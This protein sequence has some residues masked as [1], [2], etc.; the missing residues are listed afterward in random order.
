MSYKL[1]I[2]DDDEDIRLILMSVLSSVEG[3]EIEVA[4]DGVSARQKL[5]AGAT[6]GII[7]DYSLPDISGETLL[8]EISSGTFPQI[9]EVIMLSARDDPEARDRWLELGAKAV[10]GKPFNPFELL[11]QLKAHL[12]I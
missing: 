2:I 12:E 10:L 8:Q 9:P 4:I 3:L 7:L 11:Q 6:D 1:L 5:S